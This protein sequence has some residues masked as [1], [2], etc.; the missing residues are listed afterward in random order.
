MTRKKYSFTRASGHPR[1]VVVGCGGSEG[2]TPRTATCPTRPPS[3]SPLL[4]SARRTSELQAVDFFC[5][6]IRFS[7][8]R[9]IPRGGLVAGLSSPSASFRVDEWRF[10]DPILMTLLAAG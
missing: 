1:T 8:N 10:F 9:R 2:E 7:M 6:G 5:Y 4:S 3:A